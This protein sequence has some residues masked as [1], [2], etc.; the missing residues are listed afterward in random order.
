[1]S[2]A[3]YE[4]KENSRIAAKW[5]IFGAGRLI[6]LFTRFPLMHI[7][8]KESR[9]RKND[10]WLH[11]GGLIAAATVRYNLRTATSKSALCVRFFELLA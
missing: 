10:E 3:V 4:A 6:T 11:N 5:W 8:G 1:M 7:K 2:M 9:R